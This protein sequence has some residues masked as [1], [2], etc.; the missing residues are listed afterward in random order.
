MH[1]WIMRACLC[2]SSV[3]R[4]SVPRRNTPWK[5]VTRAGRRPP[6]KTTSQNLPAE[7]GELLSVTHPES[8]EGL[9]VPAEDAGH[10]LAQPLADEKWDRGLGIDVARS[11]A[12]TAPRAT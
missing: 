11:C 4:W 8:G 10:P 9:G 6:S 12:H 3:Q 2:R 1:R 7:D 5:T